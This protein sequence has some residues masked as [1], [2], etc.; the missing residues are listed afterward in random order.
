M[1]NNFTDLKVWQEGHRLVIALYKLTKKFPKEEQF[2]VI[3]QLRRAAVSVTSN[4]A[5][6]CS[7]YY[8]KDKIR[9]YYISRGSLSEIQNLLFISKDLNYASNKEFQNFYTHA[10]KVKAIINGLI[11]KTPDFQE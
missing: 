8:F 7:R 6:G 3:S 9:F 5:E 4:I 1:I 11:K 2:G 10:N